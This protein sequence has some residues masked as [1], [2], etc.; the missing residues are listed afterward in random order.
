MSATSP[1]LPDFSGANPFF[2]IAGP[3]AIESREMVMDIASELDAICRSLDIPLIFKASFD[4][5]NRTS[6]QAGRGV[7]MDKGLDILSSVRADR[8]LPVLTD[9]HLPG[10]AAE[11]AAVADVLQIPAFLCRQTD[12]IEAAAAT[13]RPLNIKK[14]QFLAPDDMRNVVEKARAAGGREVLICER[15]SCFGYHNLVVDMRGLLWMRETGCPIVFDATHSAQ[16][17]GGG[18]D[19]TAG[20]REVIPALARAA[21]AVGVQGLFIET[22]PQPENAIS[23]AATQLP[24]SAMAELLQSLIALARAVPR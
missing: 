15:G 17:P 22:H 13:G 12:L 10:Q 3:C 19:K 1:N 23:D 20:V 16:L 14:G 5:A 11:V 9:I 6:G 8:G 4:K 21:V 2:L 7:G 18:G 24:L